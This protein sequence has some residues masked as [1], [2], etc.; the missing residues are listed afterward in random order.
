MDRVFLPTHK[1]KFSDELFVYLCT[2]NLEART[3]GWQKVVVFKD[4]HEK[5]WSKPVIVFKL[6]YEEINGN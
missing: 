3:P 6:E 5:I 1:H 2:T 4:I